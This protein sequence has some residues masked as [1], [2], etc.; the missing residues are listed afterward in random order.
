M[1]NNHKI[2]VCEHCIDDI[3]LKNEIR[4]KGSLQNCF[5]CDGWEK[6]QSK[7]I[8]IEYIADRVHYV[9]QK[10]YQRS[11]MGSSSSTGKRPE[12]IISDLSLSN[13]NRNIAAKI[14]EILK[15]KYPTKYNGNA[16][17]EIPIDYSEYS[18][19]W[20][21]FCDQIKYKSRFFSPKIVDT[22]DKIFCGIEDYKANDGFNKAI[23]TL[24]PK[25]QFNSTF[26]RARE[27]N[28]K[29]KRMQ[30]YLDPSQKLGPPESRIARAGRL[31]STGIR[32]FYASF[33][34][35]T[36]ISEIRLPVG[37]IAIV[38]KFELTKPIQILDLT[39]FKRHLSKFDPDYDQ[40][41]IKWAFL[42]KFQ[43]EIQKPILPQDTDIDYIPTQAVSD[44]LAN[45]FE[46]EI[47]GQ[48]S[49]IDGIVYSS[50]QTNGNGLNIA[51]FNSTY[52]SSVRLS[53]TNNDSL[54]GSGAKEYFWGDHVVLSDNHKIFETHNNE[55]PLVE[56]DETIEQAFLEQSNHDQ[57]NLYPPDVNMKM[58]MVKAIMLSLSAK[59]VMFDTREGTE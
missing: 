22:L 1:G 5:S 48:K 11:D 32:V 25:D 3:V 45:K 41:K 21:N 40:K 49:K 39:I 52:T 4:K 31:N 16:Y 35:A 42:S 15:G 50:S 20:E 2:Y 47:N 59:D 14:L 30:I 53:P 29:Q 44:Y 12:E 18:E 6:N 37:G 10:Y 36:C 28:V 24:D 54:P 43:N 17:E 26:Y 33:E 38:G 34:I 9:F 56:T 51:L 8:G 57:L 55:A 46:I 13:D 58:I 27:A 7:S 19:S 23:R